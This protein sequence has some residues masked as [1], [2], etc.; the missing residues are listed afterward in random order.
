MPFERQLRDRYASRSP[1]RVSCLNSVRLVGTG[2]RG[3][4]GNGNSDGDG[5]GVGDE[6]SDGDAVKW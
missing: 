6:D 2:I 4:D 1:E 5:D 3:C